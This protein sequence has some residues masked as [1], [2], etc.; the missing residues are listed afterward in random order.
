MSVK[1]FCTQEIFDAEQS[2]GRGVFLFLFGGGGR[3]D[4]QPMIV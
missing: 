3:F 1:D 4:V 2:G